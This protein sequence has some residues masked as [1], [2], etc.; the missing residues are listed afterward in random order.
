MLSACRMPHAA[1][2]ESVRVCGAAV[3][4]YAAQKKKCPTAVGSTGQ[5]RWIRKTRKHA[6]RQSPSPHRATAAPRAS[7]TRGA[8]YSV[9]GSLGK[10]QTAAVGDGSAN[11]QKRPDVRRVRGGAIEHPQRLDKVRRDDAGELALDHLFEAGLRQSVTTHAPR[12]ILVPGRCAWA[13]AHSR[14]YTRV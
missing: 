3:R 7:P 5:H 10:D 11:R 9:P 13:D 12:A 14:V 2:R 4:F 6:A 1:C 8:N